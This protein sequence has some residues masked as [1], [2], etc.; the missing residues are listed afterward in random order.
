MGNKIYT[1]HMSEEILLCDK[2]K[3]GWEKEM[4]MTRRLTGWQREN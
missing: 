1:N 2:V 3:V 4:G